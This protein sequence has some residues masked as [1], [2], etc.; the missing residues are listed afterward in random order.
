[1]MVKM[2]LPNPKI[3]KSKDHNYPKNIQCFKN[4]ALKIMPLIKK[5]L[6]NRLKIFLKNQRYKKKCTEVNHYHIYM[7]NQK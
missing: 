2:L 6:K 5:I 3:K 1:M 4:V 7:K